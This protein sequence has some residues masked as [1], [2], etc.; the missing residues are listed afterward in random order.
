MLSTVAEIKRRG[1]TQDRLGAPYGNCVEAV[2]ATL[3][4]IRIEAVPDLREGAKLHGLAK[5]EID[6][7]MMLRKSAL[8]RWLAE[9]H[10]V[11]WI[12]GPAVNGGPKLPP[13]EWNALPLVWIAAGPSP[14]GLRHVVICVDE[15]LAWD[16]HPDRS[17]LL[18]VES[19]GM[20]IPLGTPKP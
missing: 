6:Q 10:D 5:D 15:Q 1:V 13:L 18:D 4:D 19:W 9:K 16:P 2:L 11:L 14:R 20:L 12:E 3:L 8:R 7:V 17:G